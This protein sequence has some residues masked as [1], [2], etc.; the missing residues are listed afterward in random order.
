MPGSFAT[1]DEQIYKKFSEATFL[2]GLFDIY[3]TF[4]YHCFLWSSPIE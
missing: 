1:T 3:L 4:Q 2:L